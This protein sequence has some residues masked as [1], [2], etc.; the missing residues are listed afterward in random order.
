MSKNS[1]L[2]SLYGDGNRSTSSRSSSLFTKQLSFM[3]S[4]NSEPQ[5]NRSSSMSKTI[6]NSSASDL[7]KWT[8]L[9]K[10]VHKL[11]AK[12]KKD[13]FFFWC[14]MEALIK[15]KNIADLKERNK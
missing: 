5:K 11:G 8:P 6:E 13:Y 12:I 14:R 1:L 7:V 4:A 15:S 3:P 10:T 9:I 2:A